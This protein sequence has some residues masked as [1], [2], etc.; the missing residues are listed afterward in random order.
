MNSKDCRVDIVV[1]MKKGPLYL[2]HF[3]RDAIRWD[4]LPFSMDKYLCILGILSC[5][6]NSCVVGAGELKDLISF[7]YA[8]G[9][10]KDALAHMECRAYTSVSIRKFNF[11][12]CHC[13]A[14]L[15]EHVVRFTGFYKA[16]LRYDFTANVAVA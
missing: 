7:Y 3:I 5:K 12:I 9:C 11:N 1:C 2:K 13:R 15:H 4:I 10:H 14:I 6:W 16:P 8:P